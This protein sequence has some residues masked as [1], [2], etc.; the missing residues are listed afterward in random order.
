MDSATV[1]SAGGSLFT[2]KL[3]DGASKERRKTTEGQAR[4]NLS[5]TRS[6]PV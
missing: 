1:S 3:F 5:G 6:F 4:R 2:D